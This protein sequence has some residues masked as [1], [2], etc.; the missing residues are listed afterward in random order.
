[1]FCKKCGK[2]L[3]DNA[4]F[5]DGCGA[6]Q[7][8]SSQVQQAVN[9]PVKKK[10]HGCL[11]AILIFVGIVII[12]GIVGAIGVG[13]SKDKNPSNTG[14]VQSETKSST[15]NVIAIGQ[16]EQ[17]GDFILTV[18]N[19]SLA[20]EI[21][22]A[23]GLLKYTPDEGGQYAVINVTVE[24]IAKSSRSFSSGDFKIETAEGLRYTA[25]ML[26][27]ADEKF[28]SFDGLNPGLSVTGNLAFSVPTGSDLSNFKLTYKSVNKK[29]NIQ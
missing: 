3:A 6:V 1:M 13:Q 26:P 2:E 11:I 12:V 25:T 27:S 23:N 14:E 15:S 18:N 29:F 8:E 10:S 21:T 4:K 24:N 5:C 7:D 22:A 19:S 28:L 16:P 20:N 17:I 9:T